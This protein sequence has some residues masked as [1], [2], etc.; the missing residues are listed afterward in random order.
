MKRLILTAALLV[1][2][3]AD[4]ISRLRSLPGV[5][6]LDVVS[7]P[8]RTG[9][10]GL[11]R[12]GS[13]LKL[14][15]PNGTAKTLGTMTRPTSSGVVTHKP[16]RVWGIEFAPVSPAPSEL[17]GRACL[18]Q[19][20]ADSLVK[21]HTTRG[22]T[23]VLGDQATPTSGTSANGPL[24]VQILCIDAQPGSAI[25]AGAGGF[26]L[27]SADSFLKVT[28]TNG[29]NTLLGAPCTDLATCGNAMAGYTLGV[30][31][32]A[33]GTAFPGCTGID[34]DGDGLNDQ[35]ETLHTGQTQ[36]A[37]DIDCNG[38][39]D[40]ADYFFPV[41]QQPIVGVRD[42]YVRIRAMVQN[43]GTGGPCAD[44]TD[45][46]FDF[47]GPYCDTNDGQCSDEPVTGHYI[48]PGGLTLINTSYT[49]HNIAL[50][51]DY[52]PVTS[53]NLPHVVF[54]QLN[55]TDSCGGNVPFASYFGSS[56]MDA[57]PPNPISGG[58]YGIGDDPKSILVWHNVAL[59]HDYCTGL[60]GTTGQTTGIL[61]NNSIVSLG[62]GPF[63]LSAQQA[64]V[65]I[66]GTTMHEWGHQLALTH[67]PINAT[68]G[69]ALRVPH[70]MSVM[71][72]RYQASGISQVVTPVVDVI[73]TVPIAPNT[74]RLDYSGSILYG[75]ATVVDVSSNGQALGTGPFTINVGSTAGFKASGDA[76]AVDSSVAVGQFVTCTAT[77]GTS[78]TGCSGGSGTIST[79]G[80]VST[81][82]AGALDENVGVNAGT[83]D[84]ISFNC[85]LGATRIGWAGGAINWNCDGVISNPVSNA[86]IDG[87]ISTDPTP[88]SL[89]GREDW[90]RLNFGFQC[91]TF[92]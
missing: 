11:Y 70:Y 1:A 51:T 59:V 36:K 45:C 39:Y 22:S 75:V 18:Y 61:S 74:Q 66:G 42:F 43:P 16:L 25:A 67:Y 49:A 76:I 47:V 80:M 2:A 88:A 24:R 3:R 83:N 10:A 60:P 5:Q 31:A 56:D 27:D 40:G 8:I 85:P 33:F 20:S 17:N 29:T 21:L 57:V 68:G 38:V 92:Q 28:Q 53:V 87:A 62:T 4:A 58:G 30:A 44:D 65:V 41:A 77:T 78:F 55:T 9:R 13:S 6:L 71:N 35:W 32:C 52:D 48:P 26:W 84:A 73:A 91:G 79:G 86:N 23:I 90:S 54:T 89:P 19:D 12:S 34:T 46:A 81:L 63:G 7:N 72:Y 37:I 64:L 82:Y 69:S 15:L 50:W 14:R